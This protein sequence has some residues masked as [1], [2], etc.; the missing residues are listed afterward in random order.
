MRNH[1]QFKR[2]CCGTIWFWAMIENQE[3]DVV[4]HDR[5]TSQSFLLEDPTFWRS[6]SPCSMKSVNLLT[7]DS[8]TGFTRN[9][10]APSSIHLYDERNLWLHVDEQIYQSPNQNLEVPRY[11][12]QELPSCISIFSYYLV[13]L[14]DWS[15][16]NQ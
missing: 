10:S 9:S 4:N 11:V 14:W 5:G 3:Q 6:S 16:T 2:D 12:L 7:S 8:W 1:G 13:F 15:L